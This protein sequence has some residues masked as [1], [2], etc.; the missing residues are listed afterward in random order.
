MLTYSYYDSSKYPLQYFDFKSIPKG[1]INVIEKLDS[2]FNLIVRGGLSYIMIT[3]DYS[4]I[5]KDIDLAM[6]VADAEAIFEEIKND[7]NEIYYNK[8]TF[9]DDVLT[10][11]WKN[12]DKYFKIDILL[13]QK[14]P[15]HILTEFEFV[16][17]CIKVMDAAE[18]WYNRICKVAE[19]KLRG[20]SK[21]KTI[22]H[23]K[24]IVRLSQFI[25]KNDKVNI[26]MMINE[27]GF[28]KVDS[29]ISDSITVLKEFLNVDQ[30]EV[31]KGITK[32]IIESYK[33][34]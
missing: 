15:N 5:L 28:D 3:N 7:A 34:G 9:G 8:N 24:V 16:N 19:K 23:Y 22:N 11:F 12:K 4:Y 32:S 21:D 25:L 2:K 31:Y 30:L 29:K 1:M 10:L 17:K 33:V 26:N 27:V 14:M 13:V 20:Y 18:L 6:M